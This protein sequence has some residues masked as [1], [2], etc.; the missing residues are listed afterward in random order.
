MFKNSEFSQLP[1]YLG[2]GLASVIDI[3]DPQIIILG[4]G[5]MSALEKHLPAIQ[6]EMINSAVT[7][8]AS[9]TK[10]VSAQLGDIAGIYGAAKLAKDVFQ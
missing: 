6:Q 2:K 3:F 8:L 4:G 1:F 10:L 5:M 7:K 9:Q